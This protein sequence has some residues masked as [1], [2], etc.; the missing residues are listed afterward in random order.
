MGLEIEKLCSVSKNEISP[1][2]ISTM[3]GSAMV[4]A[5]NP[6]RY[7]TTIDGEDTKIADPNRREEKYL[8]GW[9]VVLSK[10]PNAKKILSKAMAL[11]IPKVLLVR[12]INF[13]SAIKPTTPHRSAP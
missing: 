1:K 9:L 2:Q 6:S 4:C 5:R 3:Y 11:A 13:S 8:L 7:A 10:I 12:P